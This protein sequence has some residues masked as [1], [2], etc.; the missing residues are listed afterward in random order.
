MRRGEHGVGVGHA[1]A[2]QHGLGAGNQSVH[3]RLVGG[4]HQVDPQRRHEVTLLICRAV[5]D[6]HHIE[7]AGDEGAHHGLTRHTEADHE[8]RGPHQS[9]APV[10]MKSA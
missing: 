1:G 6:H 5:L 3:H 2:G 7:A 9:I 10:L 8:Q 4:R